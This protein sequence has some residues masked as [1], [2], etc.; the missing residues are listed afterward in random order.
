MNIRIGKISQWISPNFS[1]CLKCKTTWI[2][3]KSKSLM[4][5]TFS[6][7]FAMCEKCYNESSLDERIYYYTQADY[8]KGSENFKKCMIE[9]IL[10]DSKSDL[11]YK[12][13]LRKKLLQNILD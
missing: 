11:D 10:L 8:I 5:D 12:Q 3:V 6:G 4:Y 2:F 13:Y 9:D 1:S 7:H